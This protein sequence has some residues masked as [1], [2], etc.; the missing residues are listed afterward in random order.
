M[1]IKWYGHAAFRITTKEGTRIII[2]PYESGFKDGLLT[3]GKID[4]EADIVITSHEHGDHGYTKDIRGAYDR[5]GEEGAFAIRG[6]TIRTLSTFHD[7][8]KGARAGRNLITVISA[9]GLI[10]AHLGDL[11]HPL[12]A[13]TLQR[14]GP[15]DILLLP[16]GGLYTIDAETATKVMKDIGPAVTVPMHYKTAKCKFPITGV[17]EF[18]RGKSNVR[19]SQESVL[20]ITKENLPR[21]PEI[22]VLRHAL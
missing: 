8:V 12:D 22:V 2:D 21:E 20:K 7:D 9:D 18:T 6:I 10:V 11:G 13:E 19:L 17:E 3:Y 14:V 15:V 5:I 1:E 4:E 16:V